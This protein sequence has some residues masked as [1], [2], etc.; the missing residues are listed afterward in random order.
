MSNYECDEQ[1]SLSDY[2]LVVNNG[3]ECFHEHCIHRGWYKKAE[4]ENEKGSYMCGYAGGRL[5]QCWADWIPCAEENCF[6]IK[7]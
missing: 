6:V 1:V 7:K 5:A 2:N 3:F 4:N